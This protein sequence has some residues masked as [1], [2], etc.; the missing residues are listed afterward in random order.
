MRV[1]LWYVDK[2]I[3]MNDEARDALALHLIQQVLDEIM[4]HRV[5]LAMTSKEAWSIF[6]EECSERGSRDNETAV[7]VVK[8]EAEKKLGA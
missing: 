2:H 3:H 8:V 5:E 6:E 4:L 1:Y 7:A